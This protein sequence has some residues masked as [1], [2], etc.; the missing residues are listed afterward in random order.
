MRIVLHKR[1]E[2]PQ[3]LIYWTRC[4]DEPNKRVVLQVSSFHLLIQ[5]KC[6]LAGNCV[7]VRIKQVS[8]WEKLFK[9]GR[10]NLTPRKNPL[11]GSRC[12][13]HVASERFSSISFSWSNR[14]RSRPHR[15]A[16]LSEPRRRI[17]PA[18][19]L[20]QLELFFHSVPA[21]SRQTEVLLIGQ[22]NSDVINIA[23][24]NWSPREISL[25][26]RP[27]SFPRRRAMREVWNPG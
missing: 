20:G 6:L 3:H 15:R 23:R 16:F 17:L 11:P 10:A 2:A 13:R 14:L 12:L 24:A 18:T 26:S 7:V 22:D 8:S 4:T 25:G 5:A 1:C 27:L 9:S 19:L 21:P